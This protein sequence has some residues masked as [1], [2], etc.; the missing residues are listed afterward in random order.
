[1]RLPFIDPEV[2]LRLFDPDKASEGESESVALHCFPER[3][4]LL[5]NEACAPKPELPTDRPAGQP[6]SF[7]K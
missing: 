2:P 7:W 1:M 3:D 6:T 4:A 5:R